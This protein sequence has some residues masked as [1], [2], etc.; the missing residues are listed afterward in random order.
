MPV[1]TCDAECFFSTTR[2]QF[3]LNIMQ[4]PECVHGVKPDR[5][6]KFESPVNTEGK[7]FAGRCPPGQDVVLSGCA[8]FKSALGP[9]RARSNH[10]PRYFDGLQIRSSRSASR[11]FRTVCRCRCLPAFAMI[12]GS[13]QACV[14]IWMMVSQ[15]RFNVFTRDEWFDSARQTLLGLTTNSTIPP[16]SMSAPTAGGIK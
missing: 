6:Y 2:S 5:Q 10:F 13:W 11:S 12:R 8:K 7:V 3:Y 16:T 14:V 4:L 15:T 9:P 1:S